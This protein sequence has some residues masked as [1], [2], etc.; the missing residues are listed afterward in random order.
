MYA[1][2]LAPGGARLTTQPRPST[3]PFP[4]TVSD[5]LTQAISAAVKRLLYP[6]VRVLLRQGMPF[7]A[8]SDL[9]KQVYVDVAGREFGIPGRKQSI[10]RIAII[11]GLT[12]KEVRR[13]QGLPAADDHEVIAR[14]NRAARVVAGWRRDPA[15]THDTGE[16][17]DLPLNDT[18]AHQPDFSS[19]VQR[20]SGD[21]PTRAILDELLHVGTVEITQHN[22]VRLRER[23]YVAAGDDNEMIGIMGSDVAD[24]LASI[25]YNIELEDGTPR[26]QRTVAYDNLPAEAL[27]EL[28]PA[29]NERAQ[30]LLEEFDRWLAERDRDANPD[31]GGSGRKRAGIGIYYFESDAPDDEE[32]E[33]S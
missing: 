7:G 14:Y 26:F 19:L 23:A 32:G 1:T 5:D 12:R 10:S 4:D 17:I 16:P 9:A 31:T 2:T 33:R 25:T 3:G 27:D 11:T 29:V 24:L 20:F 13:I 21:V 8:F 22:R 30:A 28:Q 18:N 6:L 15:F